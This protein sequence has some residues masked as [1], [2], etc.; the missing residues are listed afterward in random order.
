MSTT[1]PIS[2]GAA[3]RNFSTDFSKKALEGASLT[4]LIMLVPHILKATISSEIPTITTFKEGIAWTATG[5]LAWPAYKSVYTPLSAA[6]YK[7]LSGAPKAISDYVSSFFPKKGAIQASASIYGTAAWGL[8]MLSSFAFIYN[9]S[10]KVFGADNPL[11]SLAT[12]IGLTWGG[13]WVLK[14]GFKHLWNETSE[15]VKATGLID[16]TAKTVKQLWD[17]SSTILKSAGIGAGVLGAYALKENYITPTLDSTIVRGTW[18]SM[19]YGAEVVNIPLRSFNENVGT[20]LLLGTMGAAALTYNMIFNQKDTLAACIDK[21]TTYC[22]NVN[23][24]KFLQEKTMSSINLIGAGAS[25]I[26]GTA[27]AVGT[28]V[29]NGFNVIH[30]TT[31]PIITGLGTSLGSAWNWSTGTLNWTTETVGRNYQTAVDGSTPYVSS[32]WNWAVGVLTWTA[33]VAGVGYNLAFDR[34]P[35][36]DSCDPQVTS[37]LCSTATGIESFANGA[38]SYFGAIGTFFQTALANTVWAGGE[39]STLVTT[40]ASDPNVQTGALAVAATG[41]GLYAIHFIATQAAAYFKSIERP[42]L[43][44]SRFDVEPTTATSDAAAVKTPSA[45]PMPID[46]S[47][48]TTPIPMEPASCYEPPI[49]EPLPTAEAEVVDT[50][51]VEPASEEFQTPAPLTNPWVAAFESFFSGISSFISSIGHSISTWWASLWTK[52]SAN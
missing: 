17:F 20:P 22:N 49:A 27:V 51:E 14:E 7:A 42:L 29:S 28:T 13:S 40:L 23:N 48:L 39:A 35:I 8:G 19:K 3:V 5:A 26:S 52:T 32:T 46:P 41:I 36:L 24:L 25:W 45:P 1:S 21:T 33:S 10:S 9:Q 43:P 34:S 37:A 47:S 4:G 2:P 6:T 16:S 11:P 38:S 15:F 31:A 18:S 12:S 44:V 30:Q 50:A